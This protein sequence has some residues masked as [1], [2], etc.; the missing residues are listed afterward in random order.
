MYSD[1]IDIIRDG[2]RHLL[3]GLPTGHLLLLTSTLSTCTSSDS[4]LASR[5]PCPY[6]YRLSW[7][8]R[9][10]SA[11]GTTPIIFMIASFLLWSD[12]HRAPTLASVSPL[13]AMPVLLPF[14]S[15]PALYAIQSHRANGSSIYFIFKLTGMRLS[16]DTPVIDFNFSQATLMRLQTT[17]R[18]PMMCK[19]GD[20]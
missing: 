19:I 11:I 5:A 17:H 2:I 3:S 13:R 1:F 9:S 18:L 12:N 15:R 6:P 8:S 20:I 16:Y 4:L 14:T 10:S 7:F